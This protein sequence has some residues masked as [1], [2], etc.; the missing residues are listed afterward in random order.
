MTTAPLPSYLTLDWLGAKS[1]DERARLHENARRLRDR[2]DPV[3]QAVMDFIHASGLPLR[4][5]GLNQDGPVILE[6]RDVIRSGDGRAACLD[7][8]GRALP[9]LAGVEPPIG[10]RLG[11]RHHP[12]DLGTTGAGSLVGQI[13]RH[14]GFDLVGKGDRPPGAVAKTA[15]I[16][17]P[18]ER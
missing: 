9:A 17:A 16:W 4:A 11:A 18:R 3:G 13:M 5:R 12:L 10:A 2:G 1:P 7:A 8:A 6:M 15:A 14:L